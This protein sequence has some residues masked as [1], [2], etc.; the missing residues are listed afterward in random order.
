MALI[1]HTKRLEAKSDSAGAAAEA[2]ELLLLLEELKSFF[3]KVH[4]PFFFLTQLAVGLA[5]T[6][7]ALL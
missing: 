7:D 5:L 6:I 2:A 3:E 4:F 1:G